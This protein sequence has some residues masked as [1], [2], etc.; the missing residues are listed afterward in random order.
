MTIACALRWEVASVGIILLG[1]A[2][3]TW[4]TFQVQEIHRWTVLIRVRKGEENLPMA[5]ISSFVRLVWV[6]YMC[7]RVE[8]GLK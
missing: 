2:H 3:P 6:V 4:E 1:R 8:I 5:F 7:I